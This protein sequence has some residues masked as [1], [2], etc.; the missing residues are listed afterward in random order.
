MCC[1][2]E[3]QQPRKE[4]MRSENSIMLGKQ[5]LVQAVSQHGLRQDFST[6]LG[7]LDPTVLKV[8]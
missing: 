5:H 8:L 2:G 6:M 4:C 3:G 7:C 1:L